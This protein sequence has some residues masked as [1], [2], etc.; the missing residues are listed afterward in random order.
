M[1]QINVVLTLTTCS[2]TNLIKSTT[3]LWTI[4]KATLLNQQENYYR[5]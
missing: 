2:K 4:T 1:V 3:D 5:K